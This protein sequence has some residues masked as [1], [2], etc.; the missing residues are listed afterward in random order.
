MQGEAFIKKEYSH[1]NYIV[2]YIRN[3]M[4]EEDKQNNLSLTKVL[5]ENLDYL[6]KIR[7]TLTLDEDRFIIILD[8][9]RHDLNAKQVGMLYNSLLYPTDI[10]ALAKDIMINGGYIN[11]NFS[12]IFPGNQTIESFTSQMR[13][14][15]ID[16]L[17][18]T[19]YYRKIYEGTITNIDEEIYRLSQV[20]EKNIDEKF[21]Q[22]TAILNS[23]DF[24]PYPYFPKMTDQDKQKI[25]ALNK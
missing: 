14:N 17:I 4:A 15:Y 19:Y 3:Q 12:M 20:N 1:K 22:L 11:E 24:L 8:A 23:I 7:K 5:D 13:Q 2:K 25:K 9:L 10:I 6:K 21:K 18:K 16:K